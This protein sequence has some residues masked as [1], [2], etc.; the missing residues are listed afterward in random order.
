MEIGD[1]AKYNIQKGNVYT[2][3]EYLRLVENL[4]YER[5]KAAAIRYISYSPRTSKET[6]DKLHSLEFEATIIDKAM[7]F[8][9]KYNYVNDLEYA[10]AYI[11]SRIKERRY[12][13]R[14]IS[15]E[16]Q[17]KGIGS[18]ISE[19]ILEKYEEDEYEA[20]MY[21]YNKRTKGE[22]I[23]DYKEQGKIIRYLQSR[24]YTYTIIERVIQ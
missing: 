14:K 1:I 9:D 18:D 23:N 2:E 16:L 3:E 7:D 22:H 6:I 10:E 19:P 4:Q 8:L 20:A 24:G 17:T 13:S 11:R 15:Y 21:L 12:G 5:A